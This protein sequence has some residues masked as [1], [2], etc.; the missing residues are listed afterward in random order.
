MSLPTSDVP[1]PEYPRPQMVRPDW[2]NLNGTW[3]F[4]I[5]GGD[6]GLERG[7][8]ESDLAGEITVPF[9]PESELSGVGNVDFMEAVWYRRTVTIPADWAGKKALLHF[10]A[11]DH[12]T[13][14][15]VNGTEVVRHR[16]GFSPFTADLDGVAAP[17]EE[18]TIVVR[19]RD[20]RHTPQARGKQATK[21]IN[22]E[23]N[24]TRTTGIW[25]TVWLEP[26]PHVHL[27]RPR[28]TPDVATSSFTV[29]APL[30]NNRPG[31]S[32]RVTVG[33]A[34]GAIA[35]ATARAD[36]DLAPSLRLEVPA[37]RVHLWSAGDGHLYDVTVELLDADGAVV[38]A[39]DSYAGLRS[40]SIDGKRILINGKPV[41]QRLVLDQGYYPDG[42]MTAP[43]DDALVRD[44][45]L[46]L[47]AGFNGARLH[48]K[49]F[50]ER[51]L[52]HADRLGYLVWGEFGDWGVGGG[53]PI[54]DHQR[55]TASFTT[56]WLEI[57][58]RDV[59]HPSIVG[60]CPLNETWQVLHD[61]ITDLDDVMRGMFL[62]TKLAD[63]SR[64]VLDTSGYSHRVLETD[65]YDSH[66]YEQDP[67]KFRENQ[68]GLADGTPFLNTHD[69][70]TISQ[71]Y[72]GQPY[73]VSEYGGIW[74][75]PE[76]AASV[77]GTDRAESWGYGQRVQD[78]EEFQVRFAGLTDVLL[79]D[80][81]M[82]GYCYTQLTDVFQEQNGIY[83]FDR[84][85]K[86]D[87]DRV[88]AVQQRAAAIELADGATADATV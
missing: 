35:T 32:V 66:D 6:S 24:Y 86:L 33:D 58:E 50:E 62:A 70:R 69:G 28:I 61:R 5:D 13:T 2:L 65:V 20:P 22:S 80:E 4:E 64:P 41:F 68:A 39:V 27:R 47:E 60:W 44:I 40:V 85:T 83:R 16:G 9:A 14:V 21:F 88:R 74:W 54:T 82:F 37:D 26:V 17:G 18:A 15:W 19:A 7:L 75:N 43:T 46:S 84:S 3:Q 38:D 23:C 8:V 79:D 12:D 31:F 34:D 67:A 55:V 48:Q 77:D 29:V 71:G 87:V 52:Y 63:P 59:S 81:D 10:G 56:Q 73:F 76:A 30:S 42:I 57:L 45:E 36:V 53:G 51:F 78:E 72:A 49:V 25:Q 1:R 11:V